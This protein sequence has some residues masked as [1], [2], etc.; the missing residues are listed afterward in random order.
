MFTSRAEHRLVL[1]I[2]NADLRLTEKGRHA[3]LVGDERWARFQE[4][5]GRLA[6]NIARL[7]STC[8]RAE[9]GAR[10]PAGQLLKQPDVSI[11]DLRARGL[12]LEVDPEGAAFDLATLETVVK[13]EGYLR[14]Q[15][16][17]IERARRNERRRIPPDFPFR[18]VPGLSRE[19][20]QRLEEIRPETLG[21]A[22]R[23]PG[24]TPAAVAVLGAFVG[25]MQD[26]SGPA[27]RVGNAEP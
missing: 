20:V 2:D 25:R 23:I 18:Q 26:G 4:R 12:D 5:R 1:R 10:V 6:R 11:H 22:L 21:Q 17:E 8:V 27:T 15:E 13:Y 19:V 16:S 24:L 9:S 3:G 14:R 7:E